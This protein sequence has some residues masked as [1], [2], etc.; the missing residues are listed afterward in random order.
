MALLDDS[1]PVPKAPREFRGVWV[2]TVDNIDW[3]SKPGLSV[4]AQ[5]A[6]LR[7][8]LETLADTHVNAVLFQ[9]RPACDALYKS[10]LEP[11]SWFL[12]GEQG[13]DLRF[14]P[15]EYVC[16][17]AHKLGIEVHAWFNPFRAG[18]PAQKGPY[19]DSHVSGTQHSWVKSY[20][21][22]KWLDPG[23]PEARRYSESVILDVV[24]R[25]DLD[26]VHIDDYFYPYPEDGRQFDDGDTF[27]TYGHSTA[28]KSD[29]RRQNIDNF[30]ERVNT[31]IKS[32]KPW[33]KFGI[34]PFGIYRPNI[35]AG[36]KAGL[37]QYEELAA[38]PKKW[39]QEGWC[40]YLVPQLYWKT[41]STGQP[42]GK[43][44]D[45]W[46]NIN[47]K[48]MHV[49]PGLYS[50]QL[51]KSWTL[52][53]IKDQMKLVRDRRAQGEVHFSAS[54]LIDNA[55]GLRQGLKSQEYFPLALAPD[56]KWLKCQ[57]ASVLKV[58]VKGRRV[59]WKV[60]PGTRFS[61]VWIKAG[62]KWTLKQVSNKTEFKVPAELSV[63]EVAIRAIALNGAES[64]PKTTLIR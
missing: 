44:L 4:E 1:A 47:S 49:W 18:H 39:I 55:K 14:D 50:S 64:L 33:V 43:L 53:D 41:T 3:P 63:H 35:P 51:S 6:E 45:W 59:E 7:T 28:N 34:S 40:D 29:W 21:K 38:D 37:D 54:A 5:V 10:Q 46:Q 60:S 57:R 9:V 12:T 24:K 62:N 25:Y 15:L 22:Y 8:L 11:S 56:S 27:Q 16:Q 36:I 26:G 20:G 30:V 13:A 58:T 61:C 19:C 31:G 2:A 52:A 23:I 42:F 32:I 48:G 17:E